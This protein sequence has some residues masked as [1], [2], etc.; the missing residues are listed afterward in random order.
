MRV[1]TQAMCLAQLVVSCMKTRFDLSS[2][3][4]M[5]VL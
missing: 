1:W 2:S 3:V 5:S 4:K